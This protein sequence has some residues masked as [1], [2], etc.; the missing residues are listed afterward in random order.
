MAGMIRRVVGIVVTCPPQSYTILG[1]W[2]IYQQ[3]GIGMIQQILPSCSFPAVNKDVDGVVGVRTYR[4]RHTAS[5]KPFCFPSISKCI[6][7]DIHALDR[8]RLNPN[9]AWRAGVCV[10][11]GWVWYRS[12]CG[13]DWN[14]GVS[15]LFY[16]IYDIWVRKD[17]D[18][19]KCRSRKSRY[20]YPCWNRLQGEDI[21]V[22]HSTTA[23]ASDVACISFHQ[24]SHHGWIV[25]SRKL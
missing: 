21:I 3:Q 16:S 19:M 13:H 20:L 17:E 1:T 22:L 2:T 12:R 14:D 24:N 10:G 25:R 11:D 5:P 4:A 9:D 18:V 23:V 6:V 15:V 8:F 7:S